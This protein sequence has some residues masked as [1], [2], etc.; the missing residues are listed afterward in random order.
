MDALNSLTTRR[1]VVPKRLMRRPHKRI[2]YQYRRTGVQ[3]NFPSMTSPE[4]FQGLA[5]LAPS[6]TPCLDYDERRSVVINCFSCY[7]FKVE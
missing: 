6:Y 5:V 3:R 1:Q 7:R 2:L 4:A